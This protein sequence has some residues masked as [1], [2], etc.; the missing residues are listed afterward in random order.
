MVERNEVDR[1]Y[2]SAVA[3]VTLVTGAGDA[4]LAPGGEDER[5]SAHRVDAYA[6][7]VVLPISGPH[8]GVAW[9]SP[10]GMTF[11][12][13]SSRLKEAGEG[14]GPIALDVVGRDNLAVLT[15]KR[16]RRPKKTE[17]AP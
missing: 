13:G 8:V 16:G 9:P 14:L 5:A 11:E 17:D 1:S 3:P 2:L 12:S 10:S 7:P 4:V 15:R 6:T